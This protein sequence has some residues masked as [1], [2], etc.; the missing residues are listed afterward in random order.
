M[1]GGKGSLQIQRE[2]ET[3]LFW[4]VKLHHYPLSHYCVMC[5]TRKQG[6]CK[7]LIWGCG[8]LKNNPERTLCTLQITINFSNGQ[9][10]LTHSQNL[11]SKCWKNNRESL[12]RSPLIRTSKVVLTVLQE[13]VSTNLMP[14]YIE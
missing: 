12:N 6:K 3:L 14:S 13:G 10:S 9:D 1:L 11:I 7:P 2:R 5:L 4:A 8:Y